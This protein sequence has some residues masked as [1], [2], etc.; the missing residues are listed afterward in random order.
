MFVGDSVWDMISATRAGVATIG[1]LTGGV[2]AEELRT[3]GA[4]RIV[5][6]VAELL[7]MTAP[8]ESDEEEGI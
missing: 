6:S 5:E 8:P 1:V 4:D 7:G 3:A 2:G